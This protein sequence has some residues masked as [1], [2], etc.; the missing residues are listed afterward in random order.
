MT[1]YHVGCGALG[2]YA[3]RI[4]KKGDMWVSKS[5]VTEEAIWAVVDYLTATGYKWTDPACGTGYTL[6]LTK[7]VK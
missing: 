4:N 7:E 5:D 6:I 1:E 2:I 3:G